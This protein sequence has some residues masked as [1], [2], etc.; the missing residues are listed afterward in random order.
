MNIKNKIPKNWKPKD[1]TAIKVKYNST[2]GGR[3]LLSERVRKRD[4]WTC[5]IC[6]KIWEYGQRR[7][8]V[9]HLDENKESIHTCENY[10]N[11]N[12]MITL[13]HKCH[14]NLD[15]VRR[16]MSIAYRKNS[17]DKK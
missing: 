3:D 8:D 2:M 6:G 11:F 16:K 4:N 12:R 1:I 5:Q 13:C 14:L 15:S 9:H 10:K 17:V 7:L